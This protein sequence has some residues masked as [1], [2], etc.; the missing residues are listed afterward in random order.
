MKTTE[1]ALELARTLVSIGEAAGKRTVA[2]L[3][4]MD[5]PLGYEI[6]NWNEVREALEVLGGGGPEDVRELSLLLAGT[7]VWL[8]GKAGSVEEGIA[9]GRAA[10]DDGS[11]RQ[12]FIDVAAAQDADVTVLRHPDRYP[13]GGVSVDVVATDA[14]V[15][16]GFDSYALGMAAVEL[17]AGRLRTDDRIDPAA[18]ITLTSKIGD[19]VAKGAVLAT[20]R[21]ATRSAEVAERIAETVRA[22]IRLG[23]GSQNPPKWVTHVVNRDGT[24][25][26]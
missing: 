15:V 23:Q 19:R 22:A 2:Y 25:L 20:V 13:T 21:T 3:T 9:L 10:I 24:F 4:N 17:G 14:G 26:Y 1:Q 6:G 7:M 11:A 5:Q 8:G 16:R 18:G 12:V